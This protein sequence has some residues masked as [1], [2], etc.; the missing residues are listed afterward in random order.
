MTLI[1]CQ[2]PEETGKLSTVF[3]SGLGTLSDGLHCLLP[4]ANP[5]N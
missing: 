3:L 2:Q 4:E 5:V 1:T